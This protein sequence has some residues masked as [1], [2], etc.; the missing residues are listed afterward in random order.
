MIQVSLV[1]IIIE[2]KQLKTRL[3][4]QKGKVYY[5]FCWL[6]FLRDHSLSLGLNHKS[7]PISEV[8]TAHQIKGNFK[9]HL[10]SLKRAD[11]VAS[12]IED[13]HV[14][15]HPPRISQKEG[16]AQMRSGSNTISRWSLDWFPVKNPQ[17]LIHVYSGPI[18]K[19]RTIEKPKS[20]F[21]IP[22][23]PKQIFLRLDVMTYPRDSSLSLNV[24]TK[25]DVI[26]LAPKYVVACKAYPTKESVP[27]VYVA[28]DQWADNQS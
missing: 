4:L 18:F 8:G 23:S 26:G 10:P 2:I 19:L 16:I 3:Y 6:S 9:Y 12:N 24:R 27:A 7:L 20:G 25:L 21:V 5:E 14:T 22:V 28:T 1:P 15:L 11:I 13:L 17:C